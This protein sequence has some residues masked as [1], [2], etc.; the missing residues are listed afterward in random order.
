MNNNCKFKLL[1]VAMLAGILL[2]CNDVGNSPRED[3]KSK[4]YRL[5]DLSVS[6]QAF[7]GVYDIFPTVPPIPKYA[8][9][10][11]TLKLR[12]NALFTTMDTMLLKEGTLCRGNGHEVLPA[13]TFDIV[14]KANG[15]EWTARL[16]PGQE[17][18]IWC[19]YRFDPSLAPCRDSV[20]MNL[21]FTS[22]YGDSLIIRTPTVLYQCSG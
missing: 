7:S 22:P 15:A 14:C 12:N 1:A 19:S 6:V 17:D 10:S 16:L 8:T 11:A 2:A 21:K 3:T 9:V 20:Y 5:S 13:F 18:S 4:H